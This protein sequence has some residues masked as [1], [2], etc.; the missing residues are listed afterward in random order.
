MRKKLD[1]RFRELMISIPDSEFLSEE[2]EG[3]PMMGYLKIFHKQHKMIIILYRGLI[4]SFGGLLIIMS[5]LIYSAAGNMIIPLWGAL[6]LGAI[7]LFLFAGMLIAI[8]ELDGYRTKSNQ[9][10]KRIVTHL[11]S[12]IDRL[13]QIKMEHSGVIRSHKKM[14]KRVKIISGKPLVSKVSD[15]KGWDHRTCPSC[16]SILEMGKNKCPSCHNKLDKVLVN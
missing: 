9:V 13:E 11:K 12:D 14:Q 1:E 6:L 5:F 15:Y 10:Q 3:N 7:D 8:R 2:L 4:L 16:G